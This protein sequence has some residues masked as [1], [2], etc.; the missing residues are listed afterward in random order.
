MK[1]V[2]IPLNYWGIVYSKNEFKKKC[3]KIK[4]I[5]DNQ[6]EIKYNVGKGSQRGDI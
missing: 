1:V 4:K 6:L 2:Y 5:L 3:N